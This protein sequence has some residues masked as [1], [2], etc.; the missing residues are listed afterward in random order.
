MDLEVPMRYPFRQ[1]HRGPMLFHLG[2]ITP[3][4]SACG[5]RTGSNYL[6]AKISQAQE[7]SDLTKGYVICVSKWGNTQQL[8]FSLGTWATWFW[9]P[10]F[11]TNPNSALNCGSK[12]RETNKWLWLSCLVDSYLIWNPIESAFCKWSYCCCQWLVY[13][14]YHCLLL[15]YTS[16][17]DG[18]ISNQFCLIA[19]RYVVGSV[20]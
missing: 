14:A 12:L 11:L 13:L 18:R 5:A 2:P 6:A 3:R 17:V 19:S 9:G 4:S 1:T 20:G 10:F 8:S 16:I 15:D 7:D